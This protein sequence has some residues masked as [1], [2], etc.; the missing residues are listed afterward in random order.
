MQEL[1]NVLSNQAPPPQEN[2]HLFE[3]PALLMDGMPAPLEKMT[4]VC[5]QTLLMRCE[6]YHKCRL[7]WTKMLCSS[8]HGFM[9]GNVFDMIVLVRIL[10]VHVKHRPIGFVGFRILHV[11]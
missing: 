2:S 8:L 10:A 9:C 3:L 6:W 7:C 4:Q 1:E 5:T 11:L